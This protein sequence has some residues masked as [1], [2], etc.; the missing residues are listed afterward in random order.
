MK[1]QKKY[2][3]LVLDSKEGLGL[4]YVDEPLGRQWRF[5]RQSVYL[6]KRVNG[7]NGE[8]T[9]VAVE[10]PPKMGVMPEM[11]FRALFWER[12]ADILFTLRSTL[13]E[14]LKLIGMYILIAVML[15]FIFMIF[16]SLV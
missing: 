10:P 7:T 3:A 6:M 8:R 2:N 9:L 16:S 15:L 5:G 14:K 4:E 11:L 12:E 1:K 13:L